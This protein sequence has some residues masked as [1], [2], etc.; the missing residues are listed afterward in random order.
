MFPSSRFR[1]VEKK[2]KRKLD[3]IL[4]IAYCIFIFTKNKF[5][6]NKNSNLGF[7]HQAAK[8]CATAADWSYNI[9]PSVMFHPT[10][11]ATLF[12]KGKTPRLVK[13]GQP[14]YGQKADDERKAES[15]CKRWR[16]R[17]DETVLPFAFMRM[18]TYP[19]GHV[20]MRD[21]SIDERSFPECG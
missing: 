1:V 20:G 7:H 4:F 2:L 12:H 14:F 18:C 21:G 10:S 9:T 3:N 13:G 17:P 6:V 8:P 11:L 16:R 19:Q 15:S 5:F